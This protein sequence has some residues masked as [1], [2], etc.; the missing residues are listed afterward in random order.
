MKQIIKTL[1]LAGITGFIAF[2]ILTVPDEASEA[3]VRGLNIWWE[4]VFPTLLPFFI[5]AELLISFGVVNFI[6]VLCEPIMRPIFNVPGVGSF[7][8]IMGMVSGYPTGAKISVHLREE[9]QITQIEAERLVAFTNASSPLFIIGVIAGGLFNDLKLGILL[10]ACHYIGNTFVGI[11]MRFYGRSKEKGKKP[12]GNKVS[13]TRAFKEMHRTRLNDPRPFGQVMGDA[14]LNS[15]KTLVMV[16]GFIILFSVFTKLLYILGISPII[17]NSFHFVFHAISLPVEL[18][19]P[20]L[21]GLFEITLGSQMISQTF[22]D[23]LLAQMVIV[24]FILG[25]HGLS[26]QAQVSSIIARTDIRFAPYF[27]ARFLHAFFASILTIILYKPL[28][29]NRE[30]FELESI[31]VSEGADQTIWVSILDIIKHAG[32][33]ITILFLAISVLILYRRRFIN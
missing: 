25:F 29:V 23:S 1:V 32:P 21:S 4:S 7:A 31:P 8:W 17:A 18:A 14:V 13:L 30:A 15:V 2:A 3:S 20:F 26:V 5:I 16:G 22:I 28:Y 12:A 24:S 33:F 27:F 6:G 9:K 11:C 10:I 19:L